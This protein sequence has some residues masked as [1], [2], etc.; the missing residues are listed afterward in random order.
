PAAQPPAPTSAQLPDPYRNAPP[1]PGA[2][3]RHPAE[4][5]KKQKGWWSSFLDVFRV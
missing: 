5:A 4:P 1:Q 3:A 2:A